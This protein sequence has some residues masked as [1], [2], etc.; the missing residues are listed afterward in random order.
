M[1]LYQP[2]PCHCHQPANFCNCPTNWAICQSCPAEITWVKTSKG[3]NMPVNGHIRTV[4]FEHG[5]HVPHW[6]TC[7]AAQQHRKPKAPKAKPP[8]QKASAPAQGNFLI[9]FE[10]QQLRDLKAKQQRRA[11]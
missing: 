9:E 11:R 10:L 2:K 3:K 6:S 5:V 8:I 1:M 7:P 4:H